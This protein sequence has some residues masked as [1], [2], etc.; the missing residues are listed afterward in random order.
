MR[1]INARP[2][3]YDEI[4]AV[5]PGASGRDVIFAWGDDIYAP[6]GQRLPPE[7]IAHEGAHGRRQIDQGVEA[8][9]RRYLIDAEFRLD[10]EVIGH[11][12]ELV[13][14]CRRTADRNRHTKHRFEI[15]RKLSGPLY[16]SIVTAPRALQLLMTAAAK[17]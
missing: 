10:E 11:A 4:V 16:G 15:A 13:T 5:F 6:S 7:I 17:L 8:W 1:Q 14:L 2:P 3:L 9:W 12:A